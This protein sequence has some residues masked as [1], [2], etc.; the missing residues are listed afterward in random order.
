MPLSCLVPSYL[1][2]PIYRGSS[3]LQ[4]HTLKNGVLAVFLFY[5]QHCF[6][7][8]FFSCKLR[9]FRLFFR[10]HSRIV[11]KEIELLK[12]ILLLNGCLINN[13]IRCDIDSP[14]QKIFINNAFKQ[15]CDSIQ[16]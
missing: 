11:S 5:L 14:D 1:L 10:L 3:F 16:N 13:M 6:L 2:I 9:F 7:N 15:L 4:I 12:A 8:T